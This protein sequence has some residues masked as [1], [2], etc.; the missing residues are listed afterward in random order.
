MM[1]HVTHRPWL[2]I[3]CRCSDGEIVQRWLEYREFRYDHEWMTWELQNAEVLSW[4]GVYAAVINPD[5]RLFEFARTVTQYDPWFLI[6]GIYDE[7]MEEM[8]PWWRKTKCNTI[9]WLAIDRVTK[10]SMKF[11]YIYRYKVPQLWNVNI[12][13]KMSQWHTLDVTTWWGRRTDVS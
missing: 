1:V 6:H 13:Q 9:V 4:V 5:N 10:C 12:P 11:G 8:R 3:I 7:E 2:V